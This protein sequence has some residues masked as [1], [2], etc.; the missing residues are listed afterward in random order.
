MRRP[1]PTK[2]RRQQHQCD[3][4]SR[5]AT[6]TKVRHRIYRSNPSDRRRRYSTSSFTFSGIGNSS[7]P[8]TCAQPVSPGSKLVHSV[9]RTQGNETLLIETA[10]DAGPTKAHLAFQNVPEFEG[11]SSRLLLRRKEPMGSQMGFRI[12]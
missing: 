2:T 7:R 12:L 3:T 1:L 10:Q 4:P 6:F 5:R 9:L 11:S 8:L